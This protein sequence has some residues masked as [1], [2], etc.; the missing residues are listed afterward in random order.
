M[1][2]FWLLLAAF[3]LA[4][5]ACFLLL[6]VSPRLFSQGNQWFTLTYLH[7]ALTGATVAALALYD[8]GKAVS[9]GIEIKSVRLL[10]KT[11]GSKSEAEKLKD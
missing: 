9:Q 10:E 7:Q 2:L 3:I 5:C 6:A 1:P 4:P 11:G 8:M